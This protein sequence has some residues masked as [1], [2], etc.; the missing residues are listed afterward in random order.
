MARTSWGAVSPP[1][2]PSRLCF[3]TLA[4][5]GDPIMEGRLIR[6]NRRP[7][8]NMTFSRT[9][10]DT[11][12]AGETPALPGCSRKDGHAVEALGELRRLR[13]NKNQTAVEWRVGEQWIPIDQIRRSFD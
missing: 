2:S 1:A 13:V 8:E 4:H 6:A 10:Y 7:A 5:Q 12:H 3:S 9:L 11:Q